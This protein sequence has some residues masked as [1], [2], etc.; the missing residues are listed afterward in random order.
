MWSHERGKWKKV[1]KIVTPL[2]A[3][4]TPSISETPLTS[5]LDKHSETLE[6]LEDLAGL[7][8]LADQETTPQMFPLL[9]S[10]LFHTELT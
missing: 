2:E 7:V 6:D 1:G 8:A 4:V 10:S 5:H 3:P 9:I